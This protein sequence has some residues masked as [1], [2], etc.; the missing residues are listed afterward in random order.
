MGAVSGIVFRPGSSPLHRL[1]PRTKQLLILGLSVVSLG[2]SVTFLSTTS[3][4]IM[5]SMR[6]VG[7]GYAAVLHDIRSFLIFLLAVFL[8]RTITIDDNWLPTVTDPA[9]ISAALV[10]C[11][12]LLLVVLMCLLLMTTTRVTAIRAALV[13]LLGPV[14]FINEKATGTMV[15]LL[16]RFLPLI[17]LQAS[18]TSDAMRARGIERRKNP[19]VRLVRLAIPLFQRVFLRADELVDTMQARCYTDQRTLPEL[20]YTRQDCLAAGVAIMLALTAFFP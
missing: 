5:V 16:V 19:V 20:E 6:Q 2:G 3:L 13:R 7:L 1:D 12:R 9:R 18:E 10:I 15:S 17:L 8:L 4:A 11:W 14:P